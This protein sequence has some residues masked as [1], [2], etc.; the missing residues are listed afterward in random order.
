MPRALLVLVDL[1]S[2]VVK[3]D[4]AE[5]KAAPPGIP[6]GRPVREDVQSGFIKNGFSRRRIRHFLTLRR[7][8]GAYPKTFAEPPPGAD[9]LLTVSKVPRRPRRRL[10]QNAGSVSPA[11]RGRSRSGDSGAIRYVPGG[12]R[13]IPSHAE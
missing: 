8:A 12:G 4:D 10:P 6:K 7:C 11:T 3:G 1:V 2:A 13:E 5:R 9:A